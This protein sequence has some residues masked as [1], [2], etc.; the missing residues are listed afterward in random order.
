VF[1]PTAH[2]SFGFCVYAHVLADGGTI[3]IGA[4]PGGV[5]AYT[6]DVYDT[7]APNSQS[8][9][10]ARNGGVID[11][12]AGMLNIGTP[13]GVTMTGAFAIAETT[14]HVAAPDTG[15]SLPW[16]VKTGITGSRY[17]V[18]TTGSITNTGGN[19]N[20]LPGNAVGTVAPGGIYS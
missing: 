12:S 14:G 17:K 3:T 11:L 5:S 1:T 6:F 19:I 13:V 10:H 15:N 2:F 16:G 8:H 9:W 20:Y 4:V 7:Y 18:D